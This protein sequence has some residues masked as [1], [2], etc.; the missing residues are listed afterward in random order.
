MVFMMVV[1]GGLTR[2]TESGL[3]MTRW[4]PIKQA[5]PP[6]N[7]IEWDAEFSH[8]KQSPEYKKKNFGMNLQEF[9]KIFYWEWAHRVLGKIVG[10]VFL[11]P[12]LYFLFTKKIKKNEAQKFIGLFFLG[13]LQGLIG[14]WMVKSGLVDQPD[15]SHIRL[16]THLGLA[17]II[18]SLLLYT[19]FSYYLE[20][21]KVKNHSLYCLV[22][23]VY[24]ILFI[25][26]IYGALL[27]GLNGGLI[28]NTWPN[29]NENFIAPEA[30]DNGFN[31][32]I[33]DISTIQVIHRWWAFL[34]VGVIL[35]LYLKTKIIIYE[36][37]EEAK[38]IRRFRIAS[39]A[40][41]HTTILQIILGILTLVNQAPIPLASLH[42][43]V[44]VILLVFITY[45]IRV[46]RW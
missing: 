37:N 30:F 13:G 33:N 41:L 19:G 18:F 46:S 31:S 6:L 34:V 24:L 42:Q 10:I 3:S 17:L 12:L 27:A 32:I 4:H 44:A 8:Y 15:V 25:Q 40:L 14:W 22:F 38:T 39:K 36:L 2:L 35:I 16:A 1:V 28:Y 7:N 29:M 9:K 26:I 11:L 21:Q 20:P 43:I 45:F 5:I 23:F